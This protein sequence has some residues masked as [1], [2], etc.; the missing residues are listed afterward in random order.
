MRCAAI[1]LAA[2][3]CASASSVAAGEARGTLT[4]PGSPLW[5]SFWGLEAVQAQESLVVR[6]AGWKSPRTALLLSAVL[7]GAGQWYAGSKIKA[8]AFLAVE[9]GAWAVYAVYHNRGGK[10]EDE[11]QAF[12]DA[13]WRES[14]YWEAVAREAGLDPRD[15]QA[16]REYERSHYSHSLHEQK[17]QQ[18][19]EMIGKY[20]Q[21][22][23][24]WDDTDTH[25]GRDS[26]HREMY[27]DMRAEA[28]RLFKTATTGA[29]IA[30][31]NHVLSA[32]DAAW[33]T[34]RHNNRLATVRLEASGL[35]YGNQLLP[36]LE[37]Q[38]AW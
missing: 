28:N 30:M 27:E 24:G 7:P 5:S 20:N 33:T 16:L 34:V 23:A 29:T 12:A 21:F 18:Y 15:L 10:K 31:I 6:P 11:F 25:R 2:L 9:A 35:V 36:A 1:T 38:V 3:V 14:E 32:I 37:V 26:Q 13:H 22:N 8:V 19:Y 17:D 4:S